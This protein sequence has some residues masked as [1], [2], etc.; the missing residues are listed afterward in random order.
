L[1]R[2]IVQKGA[3]TFGEKFEARRSILCDSRQAGVT[4]E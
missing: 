2:A 4:Q 1:A 3:T